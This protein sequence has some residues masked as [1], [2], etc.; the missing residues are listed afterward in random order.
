MLPGSIAFYGASSVY[1]V[2]DGTAGGYV[3][4]FRAWYDQN[5]PNGV[6]YNLG[7]PSEN[8]TQLEKRVLE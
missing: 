8:S 6:V 5:R 3:S 2:G 1:G 7:I 4:R